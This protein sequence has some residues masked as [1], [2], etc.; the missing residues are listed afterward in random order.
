MAEQG[1][2]LK[3][4]GVV[5]AYF[6]RGEPQMDRY[7]L[8]VSFSGLTDTQ[9]TLFQ[10]GGWTF[11][12]RSGVVN[13]YRSPVSA[14]TPELHTDAAE[15][16]FT[17]RRLN[18]SLFKSAA[19]VTVL[20]LLVIFMLI[21]G[22]VALQRTPILILIEG[23]DS[24]LPIIALL[25]LFVA[26]YSLQSA[27]SVHRLMRSMREGRPIN[28][29][30]P[31]KRYRGFGK[32][33][34]LLSGFLLMVMVLFS[35][36]GIISVQ[37]KSLPT[38]N[39]NPMLLRL[40]DIEQEPSLER[41]TSMTDRDGVDIGNCVRHGRSPFA[42]AY[43]QVEES[44]IVEGRK[45]ANASSTYKPSMQY[46]IFRLTF[47]Q[48]ADALISDLKKSIG[49]NDELFPMTER[50][51]HTVHGM[52][53]LLTRKSGSFCEVFVHRGDIVAYVRY[54]GEVDMDALV[55]AVIRLLNGGV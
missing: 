43:Y 35:I 31:W 36:T 48:M 46:R 41:L 51:E 54:A 45:W 33:I 21:F 14:N 24:S 5:F 25:E 3:R 39:D 22:F 32:V 47:P 50:T 26:V 40:A 27:L 49:N 7:R 16:A 4:L 55:D 13:V 34:I 18:R 11:V 20:T 15:Q 17:L 29:Q 37:T 52:E 30:A 38:D 2:H 9:T 28:H 23:Q 6:E 10:E 19:I 12:C 53:R 44:G 1:L 42:T 8:D